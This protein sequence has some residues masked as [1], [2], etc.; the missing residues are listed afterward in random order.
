MTYVTEILADESGIQYG[1]VKDKTGG[2]GTYPITGLI[3]GQFRRGRF[4]KPMTITNANIR[5]MLGYDP[6]NPSYTAVQDALNS[7]VPSVQVLR[8]N[9]GNAGN[10]GQVY[11]PPP[12]RGQISESDVQDDGWS[13]ITFSEAVGTIN[14]SYTV[15]NPLLG[16]VHVTTH[17]CFKGQVVSQLNAGAYSLYGTAPTLNQPLSF[18][19]ASGYYTQIKED[20]ANPTSPVLAG[21]VEFDSPISVLFDTDVHAIALTGGFFNNIGSSYIE[22]YDRLGHVLGQALNTMTEME[23]F[24]FSMG[25]EAKIAGFSFYVNNLEAAGFA[26]DNLKIK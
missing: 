14:P 8:L 26:I 21:N 24:G 17:A 23:V 15:D 19:T 3:T 7:G 4:D 12:V 1:G 6:K 9:G 16:R 25:D 10:G 13:L 2:T 20:G 18:D 5:A 11:L 22:V